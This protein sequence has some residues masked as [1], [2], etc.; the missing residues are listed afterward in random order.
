MLATV[1]DVSARLGRSLE[2][3]EETRVTALIE[4]VTALIQSQYPR[5]FTTVPPEVKAVCAHEVIRFM[6]SNPG[7][8]SEDIGEIG[9]RYA[10]FRFGLSSDAK[11][12]LRKYKTRAASVHAGGWVPDAV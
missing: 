11:A 9:T 12:V 6:N 8:L 3:D 7:I 4:D 5:D 10:V 2:G 1:D